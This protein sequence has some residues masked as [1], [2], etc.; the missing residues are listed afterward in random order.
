MEA[1]LAFEVPPRT[2]HLA[3]PTVRVDGCSLHSTV[4]TTVTPSPL[5]SGVSGF[6]SHYLLILS[7]YFFFKSFGLATAHGSISWTAFPEPEQLQLAVPGQGCTP[8][9]PAVAHRTGGL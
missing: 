7:S 4:H 1:G 3:L 2:D 9:Q 8:V 5:F 6:S